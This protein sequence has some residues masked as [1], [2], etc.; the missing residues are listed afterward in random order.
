[1]PIVGGL[2]V[3][4]MNTTAAVASIVAGLAGLLAG[5]QI[6]TPAFRWADP[7]LVGIVAAIFA[8]GVAMVAANRDRGE[9]HTR[10]GD[11]VS[12]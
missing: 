1:V 5:W 12:S 7:V 3:R 10:S 9:S 11:Q 4:R 2:Y 6:I 8:A